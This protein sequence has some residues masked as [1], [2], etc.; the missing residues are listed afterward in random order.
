MTLP[1]EYIARLGTLPDT[2]LD[3]MYNFPRCTAFV[4]RKRLGIDRYSV[5]LESRIWNKIDKSGGDDSCWLW[6][7]HRNSKGY[8]IIGRDGSARIATR[9]LMEVINKEPVPKNR[10]V[11]H[12]CDNPPC[13]NPK[14]LFIGTAKENLIDSIQKGRFKASEYQKRRVFIPSKYCRNGHERTPENTGHNGHCRF[15][16][17]CH[18]ASKKRKQAKI[19]ERR[20]SKS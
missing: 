4:A 16:L 17:I 15:C 14:H 18:E 1:D 8:G 3:K 2:D 5:S 6:T 7:G 20:I 11:C 19:V 13:C 10:M 12:H 9:S